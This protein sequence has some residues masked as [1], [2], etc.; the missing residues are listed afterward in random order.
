MIKKQYALIIFD[1]DGTLYDS[2]HSTLSYLKQA[3]IDL[4]FPMF[5]DTEFT[6]LSGLSIA[7]IIDALYSDLPEAN[8][9][10]LKI[11]YRFHALLHQNSIILYPDAKNVLES[12]RSQGYLLG[13]ATG[14]GAEGLA[15]DLA[16]LKMDSWFDVTRTAD[17]TF[18]KPHPLMLEQIMEILNVPA[19]KTLFIGDS[20]L[21]MQ[22]A[23]NAHVDAIGVCHM[24]D[25]RPLLLE[26]G[27]IAAIS[28]LTELMD[29]LDI[30]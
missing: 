20:I 8:R 16:A 19:K 26:H 24:P 4:K 3:V 10:M 15:R 1:W 11:R 28:T 2:F 21:D 14:K 22:T 6:A 5:D 27:A 30:K 18:P 9:E 23:T 17:K 29:Y 7:H 13:I 12:L 25:Q